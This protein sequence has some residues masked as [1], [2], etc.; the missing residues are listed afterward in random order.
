M[1]DLRPSGLAADDKAKYP[2]AHQ[3]TYVSVWAIV[4]LCSQGMGWTSTVFTKCHLGGNHVMAFFWGQMHS[5]RTVWI[6]DTSKMHLAGMALKAVYRAGNV[7]EIHRTFLRS[8][9]RQQ[10]ETDYL[11]FFHKSRELM[12]SQVVLLAQMGQDSTL[13]CGYIS[14]G[15]QMQM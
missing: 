3:I 2:W 8:A 15:V 5:P 10:L 6:T 7:R 4:S 1:G 9:P 12:M 11:A 13:L 14:S